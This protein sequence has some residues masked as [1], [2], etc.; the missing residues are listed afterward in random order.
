MVTGGNRLDKG[1]YQHGWFLEPTV[2]IDV[3]PKMRIA[4]EEIFGPVVRLF[5]ATILKTQSRSPTGS[6]M[7][8]RRL[9]TRRM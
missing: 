7:G 5:P 9:S 6:S 4:Q 1:D 8:C 2:F 3:D